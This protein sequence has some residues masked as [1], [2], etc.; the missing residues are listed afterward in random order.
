MWTAE[1]M[2]TDHERHEIDAE[3]SRF[4]ERRAASIDALKI[5]ARR[6]RWISDEDLREVAALLGMTPAELDSVATFY[7][8][9]HRRPVGR[10]VIYLCTSISC[11]ILGCDP[12]REA[13]TGRL[14]IRF[15]ET[16]ADGRFT[17]V[18]IACLGAC[19]HAPTLRIDGDLHRDVDPARIDEVLGRY[20]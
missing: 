17:M 4:T 13:I 8:L 3:A 5:V 9:I 12:L 6:T 16:T 20:A 15:G 19:D 7:N 11:W 18:P 14:G 1:P 2:L 10:H